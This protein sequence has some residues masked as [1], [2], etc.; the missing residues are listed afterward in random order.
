[1]KRIKPRIDVPRLSEREK[2]T[3][4]ESIRRIKGVERWRENKLE[5]MRRT[6]RVPHSTESILH[7]E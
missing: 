3:E 1:M 2:I 7:R 6:G 5:E 4:D